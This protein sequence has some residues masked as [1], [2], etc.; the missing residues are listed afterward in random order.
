MKQ[1]SKETDK[2]AVKLA[3]AGINPYKGEWGKS[4]LLHLLRRSLFG[5]SHADYNFFTGKTLSQCLD[6]LFIQSP[7]PLPPVNAYNDDDYTDPDV[8]FGQTWINATWGDD[9]GNTDSRRQANLKAWWIGLMLNQDHSLTEKMTLFWSHHLAIQL[10]QVKD[11]RY[12][13]DYIALLRKHALGNF[14]ILMRAVTTSPAMLVYLNGNTSTADAPNENYARELQELFTIGKG[15]DSHYTESDVA[16]AARV[17]TGWQ[18]DDE[19]HIGFGF[20]AAIH[21]PRNK[22]FS[23]FYNNTVIAGRV[24]AEGARETDELI[25]MIFRQRE[26]ARHLC[27]NIYR[28]FVY[29]VID[30]DVETNIINPMADVLIESNF[31]VVPV[32]RAL[33]G[34]EHFF[35]AMNRG[36]HIKNPIDFLV[37]TCR[38][39]Q[40]KFPTPA[41]LRMEYQA[42]SQTFLLSIFG[43]DPGNPPGVAGWPAYYQNPIF[44]ELWIN[45]TT[46]TI[47]NSTT[48]ALMSPSGLKVNDSVSL[49]CDILVFTAQLPNPA[50]PNKLI[51]DSLMMLSPNAFNAQEVAYL[52]GIL[53]SGQRADYY[54]TDAWQIYIGNPDNE[55]FKGVVLS[56]L[57]QY[58][59]YVLQRPEYQLI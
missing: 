26:T 22:Q 23:S 34:S 30:A 13:Y 58:Y 16:A 10:S 14:K 41:N 1:F 17:L 39:F 27:C 36:S 37:G 55:V 8:P 38:Q 19:N 25:N 43:M 6:I 33:L 31:E 11:S 57:R 5:V 4:Q 52:K 59:T 29:Y 45:S 20:N 48:D 50:D 24:G 51:E 53:L 12:S 32:I 28:W 9:L 21:D 40:V 56:R 47:R 3:R 54:W 18:D 15:P 46:L 42:W 44:H 35:D 2:A 49:Q 7:T